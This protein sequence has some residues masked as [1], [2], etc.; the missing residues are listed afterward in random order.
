MIW[1]CTKEGESLRKELQASALADLAEF[2]E[3]N[4]HADSSRKCLEEFTGNLLAARKKWQ[5]ES[6]AERDES[7]EPL[8]IFICPSGLESAAFLNLRTPSPDSHSHREESLRAA[9]CHDDYTAKFCRLHNRAQVMTLGAE[10]CGAEIAKVMVTTFLSTEFEGGRH[11]GRVE[12]IDAPVG[13]QSS[14]S[15]SASGGAGGE[16]AKL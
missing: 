3:T 10:T 1:G 6:T 16:P 2:V 14:A 11:A 9:S 8:G 5:S 12:K 4:V 15:V 13:G 7:K